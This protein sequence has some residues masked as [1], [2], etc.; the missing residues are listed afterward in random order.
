MKHLLFFIVGTLA[1]QTLAM[2]KAAQTDP[3]IISS[4]V[5]DKLWDNYVISARAAHA[6]VGSI[7]YSQNCMLPTNWTIDSFYVQKQYRK[8]GTGFLLFKK[9]LEDIKTHE[10]NLVEWEVVPT[11]DGISQHDLLESYKRFIQKF[12]PNL[13]ISTK[14]NTYRIGGKKLHAVHLSIPL[15]EIKKNS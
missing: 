15:R 12:D 6:E 3:V 1:L 4:P 8:K 11:D 14:E 2:E 9:C 10:G 5:Y 7:C 13:P